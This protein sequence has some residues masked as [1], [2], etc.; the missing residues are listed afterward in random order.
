MDTNTTDAVCTV[1]QRQR[2]SLRMRYS[3]L[4]PRA[5]MFLCDECFDGKKEPRVLV[6]LMARNPNVGLAGVRDYIRNHRYYG[7]KIRAEELI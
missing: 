1:C 6:V 7:D 5:R 2:H 3:K 4:N